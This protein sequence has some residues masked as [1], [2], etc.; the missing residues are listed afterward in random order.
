[1]RTN[2]IKIQSQFVPRLARGIAYAEGCFETCR[3]VQGKVFQQ[4]LHEQRLQ[5][6]MAAYGWHIEQNTLSVWFSHAINAAAKQGDDI[7][8]RLTVAG[9]EA[10]WGLFAE[11]TPSF[12]VQ[13]MP[14]KPRQPVHLKA[15]QW[16]FPLHEKYAKFTSDY[17][18]GLRA[19][20]LWK[21]KLAE[22]QQALV[23]SEHSMVLGTLTSNIALYR[24]GQ[25]H[26]PQGMGILCGIVRNDLL[27]Q[28]VLHETPC[29]ISW[30]DDCEAMACLNSGVFVQKVVSINQRVLDTEHHAYLLLTDA[31]RGQVG[32]KINVE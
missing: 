6:A 19:T 29:P 21:D 16:P 30:L 3:V 24:E 8:L 10:D 9:G 11:Q 5:K 2:E 1:M 17:A 25:W 22:H 13:M 26:T 15:V 23:C 4:N 31:L 7:L 12:Y 18:Q 20:Q 32:V 27:Q 14:V 28:G